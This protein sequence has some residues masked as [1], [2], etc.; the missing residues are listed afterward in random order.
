MRDSL[1]LW[2]WL[3]LLVVVVIVQSHVVQAS[4]TIKETGQRF[5]SH[6]ET[7]I[8]GTKR[9]WKG[10][11]Y[12]GRL[13]YI[14][15]NLSLCWPSKGT[16]GDVPSE[17]RY[18]L[19]IPPDGLPVALLVRGGRCSLEE[20]LQ[21]AKE[22]LVPS[23]LVHYLIIDTTSVDD[24]ENEEDW[25]V[26][27]LNTKGPIDKTPPEWARKTPE[28]AWRRL[29]GAWNGITESVYDETENIFVPQEINDENDNEGDSF[30]V[31]R[32]STRVHFDLLN[33]LL[34]LPSD[35]R[36]IDGGPEILLDSRLMGLFDGPMAVWIAL[37]ALL[38]ACACS[39]LLIVT[40]GAYQEEEPTPQAPTRQPRRRLTRE[41]VRTF[42]PV[43][44]FDGT[45]LQFLEPTTT[46]T[47]TAN[48]TPEKPD[49]QQGLLAS[50]TEDPLVAEEPP[51]P[52][53][54]SCCS[55]CLD[56]YEAGDKCRC[57]PC[58][59][60]FHAKC[61]GKWLVERS[62]TCP[63][64][65][66]ELFDDEDEEEE[67]ED[68]D[69][70]PADAPPQGEQQDAPLRP[71]IS[72]WDRFMSRSLE[73]E[74]PPL[75]GSTLETPLLSEEPVDIEANHAQ[76]EPHQVPTSS[77]FSS[78]WRQRRRLF[79]SYGNNESSSSSAHEPF[80]VETTALTPTNNAAD[81]LVSESTE[82]VAAM[83]SFSDAET[84]TLSSC[85]T[86][87]ATATRSLPSATPPQPRQASI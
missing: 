16:V 86:E 43:Y 8:Q 52:V 28:S 50:S 25:S 55:I 79:R 29:V 70:T 23:G 19:T 75:Q 21:V 73:A 57:L 13:Q 34:H 7:S 39:F 45:R 62:A 31:V 76:S 24:E 11:E 33:Y 83:P 14:P 26:P 5:P 15:N 69:E 22:A 60:G 44:R 59:H 4:I 10:Y 71:S 53:E 68:G 32:V 35:V 36:A 18:N 42:L 17:Y 30:Y 47:N 77:S 64:C 67:E 51:Q 65:K 1:S 48:Q 87:P 9:F 41:Q 40:H 27:S 72:W 66:K 46:K 3:L 85:Q 84:A 12:M 56:D 74:Q 82:T 6:Q 80:G 37:S 54:F 2:Q 38:S 78:W 63:L 49:D 20:K 61:I 58:S 81:P